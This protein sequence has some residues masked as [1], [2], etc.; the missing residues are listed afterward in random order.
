MFGTTPRNALMMVAVF[1]APVA[2]LSSMMPT[3]CLPRKYCASSG[4]HL[5]APP[6]LVVATKP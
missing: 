2:S 1:L 6:G 5:P 3:R 4:C